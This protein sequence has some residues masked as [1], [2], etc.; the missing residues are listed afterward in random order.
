VG[1]KIIQLAPKFPK[2]D[3]M[4]CDCNLRKLRV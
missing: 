3:I 1:I 2:N 4:S